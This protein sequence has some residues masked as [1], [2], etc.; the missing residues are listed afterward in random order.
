MR[1]N[2]GA[3]GRPWE[4]SAFTVA[5][6]AVRRVSPNFQRITLAGAG[7][8]HF[9]PWGLDQRIKLVLPL[10][11]GRFAD[12]GLTDVPTPHPRSWYTRWKSL[13][14]HSRNPLRTYTPAEIRPAAGE[15]D[16]DVF[17]HEPAGP[18]S[19]WA[20]TCAPGDRLIVTGPDARAG[21][22]GYGIHFTPPT[23]PDRLLLAGDESAVPAI[24]NIVRAQ[25]TGTRIDVLAELADAADLV[26]D[27]LAAITT[28]AAAGPAPGRALERLVQEWADAESAVLSG[29]NASTYAWIAGET[30]AVTRI[31]RHLTTAAGLAP[32]Q[33]SFLG[34]W[35][36]GGPLVG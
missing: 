5:V 12:V 7:L 15:I 9:A 8:R 17:L 29:D 23:R 3:D 22:T 2:S 36:H 1:E 31:R 34:Y 21:Y 28:L 10:P 24:R 35:K 26:D 18:A 30:G 33:V 27:D 20:T 32:D 19:R 4:Y 14:E 16:V 11:G 13:P 6:A 25:P